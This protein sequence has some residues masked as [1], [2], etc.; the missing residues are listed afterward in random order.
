MVIEQKHIELAIQAGACETIQQYSPG[1]PI[2]EIQYEDLEWFEQRFPNESREAV[3][4]LVREFDVSVKGNLSLSMCGYYSSYYDVDT[5]YG[6]NYGDG[7]NNGSGHG[8][9]NGYG[10]YAYYCDY[11]YGYND[12]YG[13]G[14]GNGYGRGGECGGGCCFSCNLI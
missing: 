10:D 14:F 8:C 11:G 2:N 7:H 3:K 4:E 9:G 13:H 5:D 12:G 6:N 1:M